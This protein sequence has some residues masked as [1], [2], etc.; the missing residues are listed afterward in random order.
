M[1]VHQ[2]VQMINDSVQLLPHPLIPQT[3]PRELQQQP[4]TPPLDGE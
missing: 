3:V 1:L 4:G 2:R